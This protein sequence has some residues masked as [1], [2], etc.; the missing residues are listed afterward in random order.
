METSA[1]FSAAEYF[2]MQRVSMLFVWDELLEG[3]TWLHEFS[4][5]EQKRQSE[6]NKLIFEAAL[7]I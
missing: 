6:A 2:D 4:A 1:V 7:K 3:R 5:E